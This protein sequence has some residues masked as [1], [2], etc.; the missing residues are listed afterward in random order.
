MIGMSTNASSTDGKK[1][2]L[3]N[4]IFVP[5]AQASPPATS[6][7][8]RSG[9]LLYRH[10]GTR[11]VPAARSTVSVGNLRGVG[12]IPRPLSGI[13]RAPRL[14]LAGAGSFAHSELESVD[15]APTRVDV[16]AR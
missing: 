12:N 13:S 1:Y 16:K 6:L 9:Q 3:K 4:I 11:A 5:G 10:A 7:K 2:R 14:H 15:S 8:V